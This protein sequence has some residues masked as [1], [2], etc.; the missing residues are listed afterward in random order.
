MKI[1][2]I[3]KLILDNGFDVKIMGNDTI[4]MISKDGKNETEININGF[5][6][7]GMYY[8]EK[9]ELDLIK[10]IIEVFCNENKM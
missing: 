4:V 8:Y 9:T 7:F 1:C 3:T 10:Q 6:K 5:I 2:I